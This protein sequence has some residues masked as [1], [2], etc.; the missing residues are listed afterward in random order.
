MRYRG[1]RARRSQMSSNPRIWPKTVSCCLT[2]GP[3]SRAA[4]MPS[5]PSGISQMCSSAPL[6]CRS[7]GS[8]SSPE[9]HAWPRPRSCARCSAA[10]RRSR[11]S[12]ACSCPLPANL[13]LRPLPPG[14]AREDVDDFA[15]RGGVPV[16]RGSLPAINI[17]GW[18]C[19]GRASGSG[20]GQHGSPADTRR[21]FCRLSADSAPQPVSNGPKP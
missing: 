6:K 13:R 4:M 15:G 16:R 3:D 9:S 8:P 12:R 20:I 1:F 19:G 2:S 11:A 21:V 18:I 14:S 5:S 17:A 7:S 10:F